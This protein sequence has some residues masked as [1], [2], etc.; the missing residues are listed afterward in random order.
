MDRVTCTILNHK[1]LQRIFRTISVCKLK[2]VVQIWASN[3]LYLSRQWDQ[4][5]VV[6]ES[7][8]PFPD[9]L[10]SRLSCPVQGILAIQQRIG[11]FQISMKQATWNLVFG[12]WWSLI[13]CKHESHEVLP[14][15]QHVPIAVRLAGSWRL[16]EPFLSHRASLRSPQTCRIKRLTKLINMTWYKF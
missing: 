9:C 4:I 14:G 15:G 1:I 3:L 2:H 6:E 13:W 7:P 8:V 12:G 5:F 11:N 16:P 10:A